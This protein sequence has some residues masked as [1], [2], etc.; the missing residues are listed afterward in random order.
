MEKE[1]R[2]KTPASGALA[3]KPAG[4]GIRA[5]VFPS[6][7]LSFLLLAIFLPGCV[8]PNSNLSYSSCCPKSLSNYTC[9]VA[10]DSNGNPL[11]PDPIS[12]NYTLNQH[13]G[14]CAKLAANGTVYNSNGDAIDAG[15]CANN[16]NFR[17]ADCSNPDNK[18]TCYLVNSSGTTNFSIAPICANATPNACI[19]SQCSARMCGEPVPN[20][21]GRMDG[22]STS[23][24]ADQSNKE[25]QNSYFKLAQGEQPTGL[26]GKICTYQK[27]DQRANRLLGAKDWFVDSLRLGV[28]GTF[29]DYDRA[30]N[31]LPPS[32]FY[33]SRTTPGAVVDRFTSYLDNGKALPVFTKDEQ[34]GTCDPTTY[35]A[36]CSPFDEYFRM[37]CADVPQ[38]DMQ[39]CEDRNGQ[40][41]DLQPPQADFQCSLDSSWYLRKDYNGDSEAARQACVLACR[42]SGPFQDFQTRISYCEA[43]LS[44]SPPYAAT[45]YRCTV[46][47]AGRPPLS[48][49]VASLGS[50]PAALLACNNACNPSRLLVCTDNSILLT[51]NQT[52]SPPGDKRVV[53]WP[54]T[55]IGAYSSALAAAYPTPA[56]SQP[57]P[58][59]QDPRNYYKKLLPPVLAD[60]ITPNPLYAPEMAKTGPAGAKVFEC[61][62]NGDCLSGQCDK[63][64]YLRGSCFLKNGQA[65]DCGCHYVSDCKREYPCETLPDGG[66]PKEICFSNRGRCEAAFGGQDKLDGAVVTV[67]DYQPTTFDVF[68]S[69]WGAPGG[70]NAHDPPY[71]NNGHLWVSRFNR[72]PCAPYDVNNVPSI[73][74][75]NRQIYGNNAPVCKSGS[76]LGEAACASGTFWSQACTYFDSNVEVDTWIGASCAGTDYGW[77]TFMLYRR[78]GDYGR[79]A[80]CPAGE[81]LVRDE[82]TSAWRNNN[83]WDPDILRWG[84]AWGNDLYPVPDRPAVSGPYD[85]SVN[86]QQVKGLL[87]TSRAV[88]FCDTDAST[89]L[90]GLQCSCD[91]TQPESCTPAGGPIPGLAW[92]DVKFKLVQACNLQYG[93]DIVLYRPD[94]NS[95]DSPVPADGRGGFAEKTWLILSFGDCQTDSSGAPLATSYGICRP[96]STSLTLA[97]QGVSNAQT[98]CPSGCSMEFSY[99][100]QPLCDCTDNKYSLPLPKF[101]AAAGPDTYP[102]FGFIVGHVAEYQHASVLPLLDMRSYD[103]TP[104]SSVPDFELLNGKCED[105]GATLD[106]TENSGGLQGGYFSISKCK[107]GAYPNFLLGYLSANHS[108]AILD[109]APL[110][111][112]GDDIALGA[113]RAKVAQAR[114]ACPDCLTALEYEIPIQINSLSSYPSGYPPELSARIEAYSNGVKFDALRMDPPVWPDD[115]GRLAVSNVSI[116]ILDVD[117]SGASSDPAALDLQI[118]YL[119]NLSRRSLQHVGWPTILRLTYTR[120]SAGALSSEAV[121]KAIFRRQAELALAGAGGILLP[122]FDNANHTPLGEAYS[123]PSNAGRL[124]DSG[125][126]RAEVNTAG[127]PFCAAENGSTEFLHPKIMVGLQKIY[128]KP[129]CGCVPCTALEIAAGLC[130]PMCYDGHPGTNK[131]GSACKLN[132]QKCEPFCVNDAYCAVVNESA[133]ASKTTTCTALRSTNEPPVLCCDATHATNCKPWPDCDIQPDIPLKELAD[134]TLH[135]DASYLIS[136]LPHSP[137]AYCLKSPANANTQPAKYTFRAAT[138]VEMTSEPVLF[139]KYGSNTSDCGRAIVPGI[140]KTQVACGTP[141]P[142]V[143]DTLWSCTEPQ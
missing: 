12:G 113:A 123:D 109:I 28:S 68:S 78:N 88:H 8:N 35:Y 45:A 70:N 32:D 63:N 127:T 42:R 128:T 67:C 140:D 100:L 46:Q 126:S 106:G 21:K 7:L 103:V 19:Q 40:C 135:P 108:A 114:L 25:M 30:R 57:V 34:A 86:G 79:G 90:S 14:P 3:G 104:P 10:A 110:P 121:Y 48:F 120:G 17:Q 13:C 69:T 89:S 4:A 107:A 136:G 96:C 73:E 6:L 36:Q 111:P 131:D 29:S 75:S 38:K 53:E 77:E 20:P 22:D 105:Y 61:S 92:S 142:P 55:D 139:P 62:S 115:A 134:S 59:N 83:N 97:E 95:A 11:P 80:S 130:D 39:D 2:E 51:V 91:P 122:P 82:K 49:S 66:V 44:D 71:S 65:V 117:L 31:Y 56:P 27:M 76:T 41:V 125:G 87:F 15:Q 133:A 143:L 118:S 60:G 119:I 5:L 26:V 52:V 93:K 43:E 50:A 72:F 47:P 81:T 102:D 9:S 98:Y 116:L 37:K 16:C 24:V 101:P 141:L 74:F 33:C 94:E 23:Q 124:L 85:Y 1:K 58:P 129:S 64:S 112:A 137:T 54:F 138:S 99:D 84:N 132:S 18:S